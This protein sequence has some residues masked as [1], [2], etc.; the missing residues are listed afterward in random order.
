MTCSALLIIDVQHSFLH[1]PFWDE[2]EVPAF[3]TALLSLIEQ[4]RQRE[5][6]LI[7][8]FHIGKA[9]PF[10]RDS[11]LIERLPFL[12]HQPAATFYKHVHNALTDS[13]L[14]EWLRQKQVDHLI[15]A[16]MR[17]E[18]CCETTA[19]VASDLGFS[20]T[21]VTPATLTFPMTHGGITL[22]S[23]ELKHRTETVLID[24]FA[25]ISD[26]EGC[27]QSLDATDA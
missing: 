6:L 22:D 11:G 21:F 14:E 7:D 3:Q 17:T 26:V 27:I 24:R 8:V 19:R 2:A 10:T 13:G 5:V 18:Q 16:G 25:R 15:I 9:W 1:Q 12:T 20:V 23:T 4:C